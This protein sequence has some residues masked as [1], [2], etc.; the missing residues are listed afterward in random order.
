MDVRVCSS[1]GGSVRRDAS[2]MLRGFAGLFV[3]EI[4]RD[5]ARF[6]AGKCHAMRWVIGEAVC[7]CGY[8]RD[9]VSDMCFRAMLMSGCSC[10]DW[11]LGGEIWRDCGEK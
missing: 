10:E 6:L 2:G 7:R 5:M 9:A 11:S 3:C 1:E 4:W 8:W